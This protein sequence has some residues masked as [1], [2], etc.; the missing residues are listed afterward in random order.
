MGK[1]FNLA[2]EREARRSS[3]DF[4]EITSLA[5]GGVA[6]SAQL[7]N[8]VGFVWE[9]DQA[10]AQVFISAL[11]IALDGQESVKIVQPALRRVS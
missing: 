2:L 5:H 1:V 10:Q 3:E 4:A 6:V 8:G 11:V 7:E 9:F